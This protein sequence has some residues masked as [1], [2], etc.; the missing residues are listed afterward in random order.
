MWSCLNIIWT[1]F[2]WDM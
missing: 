1:D 2:T